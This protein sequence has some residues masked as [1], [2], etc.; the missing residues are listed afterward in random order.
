MRLVR[1]EGVPCTHCGIL[2]YQKM[3]ILLVY[4]APYVPLSCACDL[5]P[6]YRQWKVA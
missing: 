4:L 1:T 6:P 2:E 3:N 5:C